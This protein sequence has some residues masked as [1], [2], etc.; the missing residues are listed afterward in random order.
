MLDRFSKVKSNLALSAF[1]MT[2]FQT[3]KLLIR[4]QRAPFKL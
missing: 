2:Q 1:E 3:S 4:R